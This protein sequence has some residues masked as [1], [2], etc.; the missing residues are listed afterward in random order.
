MPAELPAGQNGSMPQANGAVAALLSEYAELHLMTGGDQFRARGY[1][2]AARA[3]AGH[4]GDVS[5]L[6]S[7]ELQRIPGVGRAIAEEIGEINASGTFTALERL[8]ADLDIAGGE[9]DSRPPVAALTAMPEAAAVIGTGPTKT[10]IRTTSGLQVDLRVIPLDCWGAALQYF[11]GSQ[12]HNVRIREMAVRKK[13]KLSEYGLFDAAT[14]E[15]IVS[16]TE[17]EVYHRLGMAWL[18]PTLREDSGE[19]D[20]A[21]RGQLPALGTEH[22]IRGDLHTLP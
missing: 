20:A 5:H 19:D 16:R 21:L 15:K 18:P 11:T 2:K 13:L 4:A 1:E 8:R 9:E 10:S 22:D 17:E 3:V 7:A 12:A 14:G 6:S